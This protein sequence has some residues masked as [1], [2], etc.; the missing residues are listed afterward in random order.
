MSELIKRQNFV[1]VF[2]CSPEMGVLA[3]TTMIK[4]VANILLKRYE[5]TTFSVQIPEC[6]EDLKGKDANFEVVTS[7]TL[8][9]LR[10]IYSHNIVC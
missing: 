7:G 10:L 2:G 4:D 6:F 1:L 8:Q 9:P 5:R 3:K